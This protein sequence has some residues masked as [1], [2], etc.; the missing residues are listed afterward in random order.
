MSRSNIICFIAGGALGAISAWYFTKQKCEAEKEEE[1][2]SVKERYSDRK[3]AREENSEKQNEKPPINDYVKTL[4]ENHYISPNAP[5]RPHVEKPKKKKSDRFIRIISD[6]EFGDRDDYD[7]IT[8]TYYEGNDVLTDDLDEPI[9]N[10]DEVVGLGFVSHFGEYDEDSVYIINDKYKAYYEIL[11][12]ESEYIS[13][14]HPRR[15]EVN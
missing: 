11:R 8:L 12:D 1:I 10:R 3:K 14:D 15:V 13:E 2:E 9:N 4:R 7:I 5:I 6:E